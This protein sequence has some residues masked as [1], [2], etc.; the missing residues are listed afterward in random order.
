M[1]RELT[2]EARSRVNYRRIEAK[3]SLKSDS[4]K[5]NLYFQQR[6]MFEE[7]E[8]KRYAQQMHVRYIVANRC[9]RV[10]RADLRSRSSSPSST[11][12][13]DEEIQSL[14][15]SRLAEVYAPIAALS[16]ITN[17]RTAE[18]TNPK[19]ELR[20][21]D[22]E[23]GFEFR[24]FATSKGSKS[25]SDLRTGRII[26]ENDDAPLDEHGGFAIPWR[27]PRYYFTGEITPLQK[28][29]Y[30]IAAVSGENVLRGLQIRH[31][32]LEV[33]WRVTTI[34]LGKSI[35]KKLRAR[36]VGVKDEEPRP[37]DGISKRKRMGKK[38]R[39]LHRKREKIRKESE[40]SEQ[41]KLAEKEA[42]EREKKTRRNREK[43]QKK[44]AKEKAKKTG[45]VSEAGSTGPRQGDT[46]MSEG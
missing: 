44:R 5:S 28:D 45:N 26:L 10:C 2:G 38:M 29:Q 20:E 25:P 15:Q 35:Y 33:P 19:P 8:A 42:A 21:D 31:T 9:D 22:L 4:V 12:E 3:S 40:L 37:E 23:D 39:I 16:T 27:D 17:T 43:Q 14:L 18:E 46:I 1:S 34:Q 6:T 32:G 7:L 30:E 36:D 24:L 13:P 11:S 41:Q